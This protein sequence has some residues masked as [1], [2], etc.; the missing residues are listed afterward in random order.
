MLGGR[1]LSMKKHNVVGQTG[2]RSKYISGKIGLAIGFGIGASII[3]FQWPLYA[4]TTSTS[5]SVKVRKLDAD[6]M[7]QDPNAQKPNEGS[8]PIANS[9]NPIGSKVRQHA[10]DSTAKVKSN[11]SNTP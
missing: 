9:V 7:S 10:S 4:Q 11:A 2:N 6:K 8:T 1:N 5:E 3:G